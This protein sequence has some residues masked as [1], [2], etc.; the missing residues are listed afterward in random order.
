MQYNNTKDSLFLH[1]N[2]FSQFSLY[3]CPLIFEKLVKMA[4]EKSIDMKGDDIIAQSAANYLCLKMES[5]KFLS[6]YNF[7]FAIFEKLSFTLTSFPFDMLM[8]WKGKF[9]KRN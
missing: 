5:L 1:T 6:S 8:E 3:H 7:L 9:S 4:I 2:F